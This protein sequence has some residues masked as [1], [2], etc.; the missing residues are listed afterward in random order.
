[1]IKFISLFFQK[2][3]WDSTLSPSLD[4][5]VYKQYFADCGCCEFSVVESESCCNPSEGD[6]VPE[7]SMN[8]VKNLESSSQ[9]TDF[10]NESWMMDCWKKRS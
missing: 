7:R 10:E 8:H 2:N 6:N 3:C 1:M 4:N 9:E 5:S